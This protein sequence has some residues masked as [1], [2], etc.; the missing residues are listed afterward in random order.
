[1]T[2]NN[3]A[4]SQAVTKGSAFQMG[5]PFRDWTTEAGRHAQRTDRPQLRL[6]LAQTDPRAMCRRLFAA[7]AKS[8]GREHW[9]P[10]K[11]IQPGWKILSEIL[12]D[13]WWKF[14]VF[15]IVAGT[16]IEMVTFPW[17]LRIVKSPHSRVKGVQSVTLCPPKSLWHLLRARLGL[18]RA[19]QSPRSHPRHRTSPQPAVSL[20]ASREDSGVGDHEG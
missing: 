19:V 14:Y 12:C 4:D 9:V 13:A 1:M 17:F 7:R 3:C 5:D 11:S 10:N 8:N 15:F 18:I 16:C 20:Q 2:Q 6:I